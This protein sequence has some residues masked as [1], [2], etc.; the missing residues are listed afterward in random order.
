VVA[1][2][3]EADEL[4]DPTDVAYLFSQL[5]IAESH[6]IEKYSHLDFIYATNA[7]TKVYDSIIKIASE[8]ER[9]QVSKYKTGG[10]I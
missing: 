3:S 5:P 6:H 4:A 2:W 1:Y 7:K 10:V 8:Q 9:D